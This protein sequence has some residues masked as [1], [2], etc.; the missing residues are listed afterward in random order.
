MT[1]RP[2]IAIPSYPRVTHD[3][4]EGWHTDLLG[5]P[6]RYIESLRRAGGVEAVVAT[7]GLAEQ[8]VS[9]IL[10]RVDGLMMLGGDDLSPASYGQDP[11]PKTYGVNDHR[12]DAEL[13]FA[14]VAVA[15]GTP[16]LAICRGHQ[17]LN[18]ALGGTLDQHLASADD[19]DGEHGTPGVAGGDSL[20]DVS[21]DPDTRLAAA[22][23]VP[24]PACLCHHHQA[25]A[26][27]GAGLVVVARADDG[28][29]EATELAD[30]DGPWIVSVQWH[31]EDTAESDP[32]QQRLFDAFVTETRA[33]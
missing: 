6:A 32:I 17:I 14:R 31:P 21:I 15:R 13:L 11:H 22:L 27:P 16:T 25:V 24:R 20:H 33:P 10:D 30:P 19:P 1:R 26:E 12:D 3:R 29:I 2:L 5:V 8:D 23:A 4:I 9:E 28:V 18:V 7:E